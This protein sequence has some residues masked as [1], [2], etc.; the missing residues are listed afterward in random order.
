MEENLVENEEER[1]LFVKTSIVQ[2]N[3]VRSSKIKDTFE[4]F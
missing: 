4:C 1:T 2:K 3:H